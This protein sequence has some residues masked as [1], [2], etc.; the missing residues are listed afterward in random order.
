MANADVIDA[1]LFTV[2]PKRQFEGRRVDRDPD[3]RLSGDEFCPP[4][5]PA[6]QFVRARRLVRPH[7]TADRVEFSG[8][9]GVRRIDGEHDR[10]GP[11]L[12]T[13]MVYSLRPYLAGEV[14]SEIQSRYKPSPRAVSRRR[15]RSKLQVILFHALRT[16]QNLYTFGSQRRHGRRD[17]IPGG[18]LPLGASLFE[19]RDFD[20]RRRFR[21]P[22]GNVEAF[23][24]LSTSA[25]YKNK[26]QGHTCRDNRSHRLA[27]T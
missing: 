24:D 3:V 27:F 11:L 18:D 12:R 14:R 16:A 2:L 6:C 10:L 17:R 9:S 22:A 15:E 7:R 23:A 19:W 21:S 26:R 5:S 25:R 20:N 4:D 13:I 8:L 1:D